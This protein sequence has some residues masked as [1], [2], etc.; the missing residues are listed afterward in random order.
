MSDTP[1]PYI[2]PDFT[3]HRAKPGCLMFVFGPDSYTTAI[4]DEHGRDLL[5]SM[6]AK[7]VTVKV[8]AGEPTSA[9]IECTE[10]EMVAEVLRQ[11]VTIVAPVTTNPKEE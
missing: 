2:V 3:P 5:P 7:A 6:G 1:Q 10:I 11:H 9:T 4:F 8:V